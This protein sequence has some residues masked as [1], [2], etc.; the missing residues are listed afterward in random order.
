M[1]RLPISFSCAQPPRYT[2][3]SYRFNARE[4]NAGWRLDYFLVSE[5]L[6]GDCHD[7]YTLLDWLGKDGKPLSDHVPLGLVLKGTA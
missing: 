2:Y 3:Y 6:V 4:K 1:R 5:A 7:S